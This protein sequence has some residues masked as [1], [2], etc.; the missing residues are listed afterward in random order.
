MRQLAL[1]DLGFFSKLLS[2]EPR[3]RGMTWLAGV[4]YD[5]FHQV[6][7]EP[8]LSSLNF[9]VEISERRPLPLEQVIA[10][11]QLQRYQ[12]NLSLLATGKSDLD[13]LSRANQFRSD[14]YYRLN[15]IGR[16]SCR[17]RV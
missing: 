12:S 10:K 4:L 5:G 17:E 15:E 9:Y 1:K 6:F 14:L 8:D 2:D 7:P 16:A 3:P 13:E 11:R